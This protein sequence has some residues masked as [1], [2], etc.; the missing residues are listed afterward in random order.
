MG[1]D[2]RRRPLLRLRT[3]LTLAFAALALV[4]VGGMT[5]AAG[6]I[7][8]DQFR[9]YVTRQQ[10]RRNQA[11]AS[12]L[13]SQLAERGGSWEGDWLEPICMA[14]LE[15]GQ[16]LT[17]TTLDGTVMWDAATHDNDHCIRILAEMESNLQALYPKVRGSFLRK[18]YPIRLGQQA[19]ATLGVASYEPYLFS[20]Q[21]VAYLQALDRLFLV[22]AALSL[23]LAMILGAWWALGLARPIARA[24][25]AAERIARGHYAERMEDPSSIREL[26]ELSAAVNHL[27]SSLADQERL[28]ARLNRDMAHELR[29]PLTTLQS[30]LEAMIDGVWEP[31]PKRLADFHEEV[32]RLARLVADMEHLARYEPDGLVLHPTS[33]DLSDLARTVASGLEGRITAAGLRLVLDL[34]PAPVLADADRIR[35]VLVNL[36][37]NAL[38]YTPSGEI[39]IGTGREGAWSRIAVADTGIGIPSEHLPHVF[40]R[41]YRVDDARRRHSGGSG[42]GLAIVRAIVLA[43]DGE[44]LAESEPGKGS[45]LIVRLPLAGPV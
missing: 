30:H 5:L 18:E 29:T 14:A 12:A 32:L 6:R 13:S 7:L 1:T 34:S 3:R 28:R 33:F 31:T 37:E 27:A 15:D 20:D 44:V 17:V 9:E 45:R 36:L 41:F 23:L 8:S 4:I 22:A 16:I 39:R 2:A 25:R 42:I 11:I 10:D 24:T 21:D 35:Q 43:H 19:V 38:A 26:A 40:E